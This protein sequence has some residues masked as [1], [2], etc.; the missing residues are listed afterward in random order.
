[1]PA[2]SSLSPF[3]FAEPVQ[4]GLLGWSVMG[5]GGRYQ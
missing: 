5:R 2:V 1:V 4:S 3:P